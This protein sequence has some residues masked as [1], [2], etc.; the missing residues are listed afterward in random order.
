MPLVGREGGET[1]NIGELVGDGASGPVDGAS[2]NSDP[3]LALGERPMLRG[4]TDP[5]EVWE[6][7]RGEGGGVRNGKN[8][9]MDGCRHVF[10]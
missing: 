2:D 8:W 3:G 4:S 1:R 9:W 6:R 10:D 7:E 5:T